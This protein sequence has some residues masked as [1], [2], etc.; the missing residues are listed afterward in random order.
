MW[1]TRPLLVGRSTLGQ[2]CFILREMET[3]D[4]VKDAIVV[5]NTS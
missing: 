3:E 1:C 2:S 4:Y 5:R